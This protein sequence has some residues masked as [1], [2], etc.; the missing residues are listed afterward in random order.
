[1]LEEKE[2]CNIRAET[3]DIGLFWKDLESFSR[4]RYWVWYSH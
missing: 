2:D 3:K 1:M 4:R